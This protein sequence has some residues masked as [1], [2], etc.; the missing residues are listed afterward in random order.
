[1]SLK[2]LRFVHTPSELETELAD[3]LAE[4]RSLKLAVAWATLGRPLD[5]ILNSDVPTESFVGT[6]F[7]R[8]HP[9]AISKL[10]T[11]GTVRIYEEQQDGIFHP[12][13]YMFR[14]SPGYKAIVG[15]PNLT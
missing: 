7:N 3:L 10:R 4:A 12:K 8:S 2:V 13:L 5:M 11:L 6:S 9:D 15:S 1:M 14:T